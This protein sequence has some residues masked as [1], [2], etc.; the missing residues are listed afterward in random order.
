MGDETC[1]CVSDEQFPGENGTN[2]FLRNICSVPVTYT[3]SDSC[4]D[5]ERL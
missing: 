2:V 3:E 5:I 1:P 4:Q